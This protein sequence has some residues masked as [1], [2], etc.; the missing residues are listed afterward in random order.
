MCL[1]EKRVNSNTVAQKLHAVGHRAICERPMKA[2]KV[3]RVCRRPMISNGDVCGSCKPPAIG[4]AQI[5]RHLD[6]PEKGKHGHSETSTD[7]SRFADVIEAP[8]DKC[9]YFWAVSEDSWPILH[10][11]V[12]TL[13]D[14]R[15]C[16]YDKPSRPMGWE[17][18]QNGSMTE[19]MNGD[20]EFN[21]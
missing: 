5:E 11:A 10:V 13:R 14:I 17:S 21:K 2:H 8:A 12:D 6:A 9:F 3:C 19:Q 7:L 16:R 15:E 1:D 4:L 20:R 18:H